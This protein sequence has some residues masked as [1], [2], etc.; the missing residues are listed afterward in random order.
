MRQHGALPARAFQSPRCFRA[1]STSYPFPHND[2]QADE[3]RMEDPPS[4]SAR[5]SEVW[6]ATEDPIVQ[7][8]PLV[9]VQL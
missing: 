9:P 6:S 1:R 3:L 5:N 7:A 8:Q 2:A 4:D